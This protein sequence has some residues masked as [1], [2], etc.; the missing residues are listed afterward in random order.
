MLGSSLIMQVS[1][2]IITIYLE[3]YMIELFPLVKRLVKGDLYSMRISACGLFSALY[4]YVS[5]LNQT[6][7]RQLFAELCRD[8]TPMV[9]RAAASNISNIFIKADKFICF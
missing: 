5:A 9:R 4:P 6:L 3:Q 8:D 2:Y 7:L 1:F